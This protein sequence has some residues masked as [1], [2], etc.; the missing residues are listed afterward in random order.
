ML[1][2]CKNLI[3]FL[4]ELTLQTCSGLLHLLWWQKEHSRHLPGE[5]CTGRAKQGEAEHGCLL[6]GF[7]PLSPR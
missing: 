3:S 4:I 6:P 5:Q 1:I 2:L 7:C